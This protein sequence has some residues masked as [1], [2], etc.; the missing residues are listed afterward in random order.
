M[1]RTIKNISRAQFK[2]INFYPTSE[3]PTKQTHAFIS[4]RGTEPDE[5]QKPRI[6]APLW[7]KGIMLVFDDV[8]T[9]DSKIIRNLQPIT[10]DQCETICN[11]VQSLHHDELTLNLIVH[12]YAGVSR[13]AG[14][15]KWINDTFKLELPNYSNNMLYNRFVY[16]QLTLCWERLNTIE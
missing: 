9:T 8:D 7:Y 11:F 12:C 16:R 4:I 13:S 15:G 10:Q 2:R 14:V 3:N 5:I 6:N 1:I